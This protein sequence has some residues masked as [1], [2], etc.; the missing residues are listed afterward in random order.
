MQIMKRTISSLLVLFSACQ[1]LNCQSVVSQGK[2]FAEIFTEFH[3]NIN[4]TSKTTGFALNR[5]YLG[6]NYT[7]AGNFSA[8]LIL[9][10]G[11]PEDLA[12]GSVPKRYAYF[13]EASVAYT[14]EK[15]TVSFG[16]VSTRF[17][18]FQQSFWGKRYLG[19]EF[20]SIYGYS[21]VADLG[22]VIDYRLNDIL[23]VDLSLLNGE[24]YTNIQLDNSLKTSFGMTVTTPDKI[25]VRVYG[26]I[27]KIK[28]IWQSTYLLFA[29]FK[30]NLLTFGAEG[31]YKTNLDLTNGH[32]VWGVS[33]TGS[34]NLSEKSEIFGRYDYA[35]SVRLPGETLQW[36][37]QKDAT[38][39]I[40]GLQHAFNTN[41][42]MALNWRR[43]NPY[44]PGKPGTDAIYL[45]ASFK[46]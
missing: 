18:D 1:I 28:G 9:N 40:G 25:A 33:A 37:Y 19:A 38:Y 34:V 13:R 45:N 46:F 39:F 32:D 36:D 15:L 29:G 31:S 23:K 43:T 2:A 21:P 3:Y 14:K 22:V 27:M 10:V 35:A 44:S 41:V 5:A 6:Y 24:G 26:D 20:Q 7:P 30:N 16:M 8:L 12:A 11:S 17:C 4:D 42:K